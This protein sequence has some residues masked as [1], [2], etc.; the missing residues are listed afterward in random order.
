MLGVVIQSLRNDG[1]IHPI[2]LRYLLYLGLTGIAFIIGIV[3]R[4]MDGAILASTAFLGALA[5]VI[6]IV[7]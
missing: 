5:F 2:G 1:L 6:G 3:P 4:F 7:S